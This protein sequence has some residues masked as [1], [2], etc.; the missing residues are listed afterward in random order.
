MNSSQMKG[1]MRF[2]MYEYAQQFSLL[3]GHNLSTEEWAEFENIVDGLVRA[4]KLPSS[5]SLFLTKLTEFRGL[6]KIHCEEEATTTIIDMRD[7]AG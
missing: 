5:K 3:S 4:V 2:S 7:D 1:S 6:A